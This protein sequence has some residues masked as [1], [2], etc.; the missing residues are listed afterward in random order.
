MANDA[1]NDDVRRAVIATW[2]A[3]AALHALIAE[4]RSGDLKAGQGELY[5]HLEVRA[6]RH[7]LVDT[8]GA[9]F[10]W[11][12]VTITIVGRYDRAVAAHEAALAIFNLQTALVF[13]SAA[14][15]MAWLPQDGGDDQQDPDRKAAEEVWRGIIVGLVWS[16]RGP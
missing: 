11:R 10:D 15:F 14:R 12:R 3:N 6:D 7:Q 8:G 9:F 1:I 4:P 13:P 2:R 16:V 5:A